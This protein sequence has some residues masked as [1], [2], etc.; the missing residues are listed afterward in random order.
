MSYH[1]VAKQ[2]TDLLA[3]NNCAFKTFEH[4][5]V[6]TSEEAA[7]ERPEY[8]LHQGAKAMILKIKPPRAGK[9]FFML[10]F[11]ADLKFDS[12]KVKALLGAKDLRFAT[13][14]EVANVTGGI[15]LGGVPPFGNLFGLEVFA[16]PGL[17]GTEEIIFNAGDRSF[18]IAMRS[19]DYKKLVSPTVA[20][21]AKPSPIN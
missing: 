12:Q 11:P 20:E 6:R 7:R 8:S 4:A 15:E 18:S 2:I 13:E 3:Q 19:E 5:P 14:E 21:I 17:F 9:D 10:V 16:D 1:P